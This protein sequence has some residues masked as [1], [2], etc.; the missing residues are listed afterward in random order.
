MQRIISTF[1]IPLLLVSQS[2]VSA[3]HLHASASSLG[4]SAGPHIHLHNG[5]ASDHHDD[6]GHHDDA[7][8]HHG[9]NSPK[10]SLT[11]PS[12]EHDS[13]ALYVGDLQLADDG[14]VSGIAKAEFS[15]ICMIC[16]E[17]PLVTLTRHDTRPNSS[18]VLRPKCALYLQLLS[19]RC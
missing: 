16:G 13:D 4:D 17:S 8:H 6:A 7:D 5:H 9:A 19:I 10:A 3:S 12:P 2:L 11:G 18:P 1:L 14:R 15:A